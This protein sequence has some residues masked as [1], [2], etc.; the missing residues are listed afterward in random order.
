MEACFEETSQAMQCESVL[1]Y[2]ISTRPDRVSDAMLD[3]LKQKNVTTIELGIESLDDHVLRKS[4][5]CHT[6]DEA[7]DACKRIQLHGF[8]LGMHLMCGL[9]GQYE[10]SWQET[11]HETVAINPDCVRI[12]PT[13]ILKDTPLEKLFLRGDYQPLSL[14]EAID[15]SAYAYQRFIHHN[16]NVIRVGLALSDEQGC[17]EDKIVG[18]PWHPA[19]RHEVESQLAYQSITKELSSSHQNKIHI[20][21]KDI[22]VVNGTKKCNCIQWRDAGFDVT[23]IQNERIARHTFS[24]N[25]NLVQ[26]LFGTPNE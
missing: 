18:G 10:T 23:I 5:R 4:A 17:G 21:P 8:Q 3:Y 14:P 12:A 7:R 26:D 11:V 25:H 16:I 6:A 19:L 9:P 20:N 1:G 15:Q 22:S 13:I 2:R 24:V